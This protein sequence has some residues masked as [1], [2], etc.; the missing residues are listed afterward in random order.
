MPYLF[1]RS[2]PLAPANDLTSASQSADND[3]FARQNSTIAH[4]G[5][6]HAQEPLTGVA[7]QGLEV[8][9]RSTAHERAGSNVTR[10]G[11]LP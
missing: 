9:G 4:G 3:L 11:T 8:V 6:G 10:S 5:F 2:T 1:K 7:N